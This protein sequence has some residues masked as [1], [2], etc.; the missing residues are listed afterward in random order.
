MEAKA[1][2][3]K[4][5]RLRSVGY[6]QTIPEVFTPGI[7]LQRTSVSSEGHS[8]PYP[9]VLEVLYDIHTCTR[10][11]RM[12]Y[13]PVATIP[14]VRVGQVLYPL[15]TSVSSV[16]LCH[17]SVRLPYPYPKLL[18]VLSDP[19]TL[20]RNPQA[21]PNLSVELSIQY[22]MLLHTRLDMTSRQYPDVISIHLN[23]QCDMCTTLLSCERS[24]YLVT[25]YAF[26]LSYR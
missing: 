23:I 26:S 4:L 24:T 12:F 15:G 19:H 2:L 25:W 1:R 14:E 7:T 6:V 20:A 13:T 3:N 8:Y 5:A 21:L 11:C 22:P 17:S 16:R 18:E 10:N 9:K